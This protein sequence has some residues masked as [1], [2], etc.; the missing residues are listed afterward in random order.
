MQSNSI[1]PKKEKEKNE[2][3]RYKSSSSYLWYVPTTVLKLLGRSIC[4]EFKWLLKMAALNIKHEGRCNDGSWNDFVVVIMMLSFYGQHIRWKFHP[5]HARFTL[6]FHVSTSWPNGRVY[7]NLIVPPTRTISKI[8]S[9]D[10]F[11]YDRLHWTVE[12]WNA[13]K[14]AWQFSSWFCL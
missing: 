7:Q 9:T 10:F 2:R 5:F 4:N 8:A 13:F 14:V 11:T 6:S 3:K 12:P 1:L